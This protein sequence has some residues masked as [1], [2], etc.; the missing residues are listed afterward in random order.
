MYSGSGTEYRCAATTLN[1]STTE[2]A[3]GWLF[4]TKNSME[5][6]NTRMMARD[7]R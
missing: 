6:T 1:S 3:R 4:C 7:F 2:V 5:T